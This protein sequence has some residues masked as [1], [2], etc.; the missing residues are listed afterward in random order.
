MAH[1]VGLD[2]SDK[3]TAIHV[4]SAPLVWSGISSSIPLS[5]FSSTL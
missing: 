5:H 4:I 3:D 2:V 1:Y